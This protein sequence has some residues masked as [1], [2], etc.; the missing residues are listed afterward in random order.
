MLKTKTLNHSVVLKTTSYNKPRISFGAI[1]IEVL[2]TSSIAAVAQS[3][4]TTPLPHESF[5]VASPLIPTKP[6]L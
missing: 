1:V 3:A 4:K 5:R 2:R 6:K